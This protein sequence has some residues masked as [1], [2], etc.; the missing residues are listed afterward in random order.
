MMGYPGA[1]KT[2]TAKTIHELT[3]AIHLWADKIRN[4]RFPHPTHSHEE[5]IALYDHLNELAAELLATGQDVVFDTN[6]NYYKDREHLR[7]IANQHNAQT[8]LLWVQAPKT[9]ARERATHPNHAKRN[10][11]PYQMPLERFE[12]ISRDFEPPG[13]DEP[14]IE[15]DGTQV[16]EAYIREKLGL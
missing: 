10:T 14:Y 3:G 4:E 1:G 16:T 2:T 12:R 8:R 15:I 13:N 5:N 11:Y 7:K 9:L 6:F